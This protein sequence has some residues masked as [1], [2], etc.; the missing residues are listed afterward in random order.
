VEKKLTD[1]KEE[2]S[3]ED[4]M[5][6]DIRVAAILEAEMVPKSSKLIK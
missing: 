2:I 6:L 4:F 1:V 3:F 5:K